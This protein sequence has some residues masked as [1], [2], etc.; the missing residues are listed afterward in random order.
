M[1]IRAALQAR[2]PSAE[3]GSL[4]QEGLGISE[5][6]LYP[7]GSSK[8]EKRIPVMEIMHKFL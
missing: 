7:A 4:K 5:P 8:C 1:I 2:S 3:S 6:F